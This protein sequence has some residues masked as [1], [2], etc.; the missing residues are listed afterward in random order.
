MRD[1]KTSD[2]HQSYSTW[3]N[4]AWKCFSKQSTANL[5]IY[6]H[7]SRKVNSRYL[8]VF[9]EG[10]RC[11]YWGFA[12]LSIRLRSLCYL[13]TDSGVFTERLSC[14][15]VAQHAVT[16]PHRSIF[17]GGV[18]MLSRKSLLPSGWNLVVYV[19]VRRRP[20]PKAR[21]S[22]LIQ[23]HPTNTPSNFTP[24]HRTSPNKLPQPDHPCLSNI[25]QQIPQLDHPCSSNITQQTPP[26][27]QLHHPYSSL[28]IQLP[29]Q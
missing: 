25:T 14:V 23:H 29:S 24:S 19:H 2:T 27:P 3:T 15:P 9:V 8:F 28:V 5:C 26:F 21:P 7:E 18:Q 6:F 16:L 22:L 4:S 12:A 20:S 11:L 17:L 1:G 10:S 13:E